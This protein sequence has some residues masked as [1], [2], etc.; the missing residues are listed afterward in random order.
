[1]TTAH[2]SPLA[3]L[4]EAAE[5]VSPAEARFLGTPFR[6][7]AGTAPA[8]DG[9]AL[10][11]L[12]RDVLYEHAYTRPLSGAFPPRPAPG[13]D[14]DLSPALSAAHPGRERWE[15]GWTVSQ[16]LS[17]GQ[18]VARRGVATRFLWP[19]EFLHRD[20]PGLQPVKGAP[21]NLWLPRES[22]TLQPGFFHVF[23][24]TA[25]DG[26]DDASLLRLYWNVAPDA[27]PALLRETIAAL[28]RY[29]LPFRMKALSRRSLYPRTDAAVLYVGRRHFRLVRELAL[30]VRRRVGPGVGAEVPLFTLPLAPGLALAEEPGNGE[31][32][33]MSRCRIVAEGLWSAFARRRVGAAG[34]EEE[35]RAAFRRHGVDAER[36]WLAAGSRDRY[37]EVPHAA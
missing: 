32:F 35:I 30:E 1:M 3:A 17:T 22:R 33:G 7:P 19:G 24:E 13:A 11:A 9:S 8:P 37:A 26:T 2:P 16:V 31:S 5:V 18:V 36:P 10:V 29:A 15:G 14:D 21:L 6:L 23:G 25:P 12:L 27:A 20:G 4:A 28:N 34:R